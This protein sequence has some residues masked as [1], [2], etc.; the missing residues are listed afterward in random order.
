MSTSN[1]YFISDLLDRSVL[2][3]ALEFLF[4]TLMSQTEGKGGTKDLPQQ[5]FSPIQSGTCASTPSC[6]GRPGG[7]QAC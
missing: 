1:A 6:H 3:K 7:C 5:S 4:L 2:I